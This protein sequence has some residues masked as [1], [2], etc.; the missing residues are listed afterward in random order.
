VACNVCA[1][2]KGQVKSWNVP[3]SNTVLMARL[4]SSLSADLFLN[5]RFEADSAA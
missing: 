1:W 4:F 5:S 3:T 2:S